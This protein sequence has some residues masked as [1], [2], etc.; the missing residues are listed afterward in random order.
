M[1]ICTRKVKCQDR[2]E[3]IVK[4]RM[5]QN[6]KITEGKSGKTGIILITD[7]YDVKIRR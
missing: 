1:T 5:V 3:Q 4:V 2:N 7:K 6:V